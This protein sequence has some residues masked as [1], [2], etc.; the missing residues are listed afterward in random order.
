MNW[1]DVEPKVRVEIEA[2]LHLVPVVEPIYDDWRDMMAAAEMAWYLEYGE[3]PAWAIITEEVIEEV[4][5]WG[6]EVGKIW[7]HRDTEGLS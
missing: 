5:E 4:D 2:M 7:V 3:L 6:D 1:D